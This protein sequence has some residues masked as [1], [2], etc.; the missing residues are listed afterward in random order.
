M[1]NIIGKYGIAMLRIT[2]LDHNNLVLVDNSNGN[3]LIDFN[4]PD[5]WSNDTNLTQQL[6]EQNLL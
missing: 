4:I 2:E 6:K 5:Y 1:R 3:H